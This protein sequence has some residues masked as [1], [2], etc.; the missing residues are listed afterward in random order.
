MHAPL[1][2]VILFVADVEQSVEFYG[3]VLGLSPLGPVNPEWTELDARTTRLALH[4]KRPFDPSG[5]G[6]P[7]KI[8]FLVQDFAT[9]R[10]RLAELGIE[11][12]NEFEW[13]GCHFADFHDLD[14]NSIQICTR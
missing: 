2:R 9:E 11:L 3:R 12:F 6:A 14:G 1:C 5:L 10:D 7:V 8:A 4:K 13:D